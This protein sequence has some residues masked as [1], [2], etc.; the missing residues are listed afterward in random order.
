MKFKNKYLFYILACIFIASAALIISFRIFVSVSYPDREISYH[1][2][3]LFRHNFNRAVKFEDVHISFPGSVV[4]HNF[5]ISVTSDFNDNM[6]MISSEKAVIKL[7]VSDFLRNKFTVRSIE[8]YG[9]DIVFE[10]RYRDYYFMFCTTMKELLSGTKK[11][12][13]ISHKKVKVLFHDSSFAYRELFNEKKLSISCSSVNSKTIFYRKHAEY[14][15]RGIIRPDNNSDI[16]EG[17]F[18]GSGTLYYDG[19]R[20]N[21]T[22][23]SIYN[24]DLSY[25][26][27]FISRKGLNFKL[28]GGGSFEAKALSHSGVHSIKA[29]VE[30]NNLNVIY[31]PGPR[32]SPVSN[33]NINITLDMDI[34]RDPVRI[35]C[36]DFSFSDNVLSMTASLEYSD[37]DKEN[38]LKLD[39]DISDVDLGDL[40]RNITPVKNSTFTGMIKADG[41]WDIDFM[42]SRVN[43]FD[44]SIGLRDFSLTSFTRG[45]GET[46]VSGAGGII[47]SSRDGIAVNLRADFNGTDLSL[48]GKTLVKSWFPISSDSSFKLSSSDT[49]A[50]HIFSCAAYIIER[51]YMVADRDRKRGY[52]EIFFLSKPAGSFINNNDFSL[53]LTA[54]KISMGKKAHL[55]NF[56]ST[57]N[58]KKGVLLLDDF[59]L[60]GY[61][62]IFQL[63]FLGLFNRDYPYISMEGGVYTLDLDSLSSDMKSR[64]TLG[65]NLLCN[66]DYKITA[67]RLSHIIENA[68]GTFHMSGISGSLENTSAQKKIND[69]LNKN[70]YSTVDIST[71]TFNTA[72]ATVSQRGDKFYFRNF[73]L[74]GEDIS[75]N[76]WGN[77][78]YP[79]G[80][81]ASLQTGVRDKNRRALQIPL[82]LTGPLTAPCLGLR[83]NSKAGKVCF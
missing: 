29:S 17:T 24:F 79:S 80:L 31:G 58:L 45:T 50:R 15:I 82:I 36:R 4:L 11:G 49:R 20:K 56:R 67:Y 74:S 59:N 65:G 66:F 7:S 62:G 69:F 68:E 9:A 83:N 19:K 18:R 51:I 60:E 40:S 16:S 33:E 27:D 41:N 44:N 10:K 13:S 6:S 61:G 52:E 77:Y 78:V 30:T 73:S 54:D 64:C 42:K 81:D 2:N 39:Y 14:S 38:F 43:R 63:K 70:G 53:K 55:D 12:A 23:L 34:S 32:F 35:L 37:N 71:I 28:T 25:L 46:V 48:K 57:L 26:N 47:S 8:F 72:S 1:I 3:E 76:S 21:I 75:I 22:R 5:N